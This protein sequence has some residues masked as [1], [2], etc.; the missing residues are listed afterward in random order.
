MGIE[1]WGDNGFYKR[2]GE[3]LTHDEIVTA[4]QS[5][6]NEEY[7]FENLYLV[8]GEYDI[9][10][11]PSHHEDFSSSDGQYEDYFDDYVNAV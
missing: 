5:M 8:D 10:L 9:I 7:Q 2:V 4:W 6:T 3:L 11:N 1:V